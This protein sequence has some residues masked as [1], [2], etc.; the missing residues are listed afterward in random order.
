[1]RVV[2]V[3]FRDAAILT[4]ISRNR[5]YYAQHP[6]KLEEMVTPLCSEARKIAEEITDEGVSQ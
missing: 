4:H 3:P 5:R 1:M 2:D 6:R